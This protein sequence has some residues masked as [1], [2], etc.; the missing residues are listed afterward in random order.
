MASILGAIIGRQRGA[1]RVEPR[2]VIPGRQR[3]DIDV[4]LGRPNVA[5]LL[6]VELRRLLGVVTIYVN[7]VT[8]RVLIHHD[9]GLSSAE[10]DQFVREAVVLVVRQAMVLTTPS[11]HEPDVMPPQLRHRRPTSSSFTIAGSAVVGVAALVVHYRRSPFVRLGALLAATVGVVR[12]AWRKASQARPTEPSPVGTRRHHILQIVGSHRRQFYLASALSIIGQIL[13]MTPALI[14]GWT[15]VV[16]INGQSA[17]FAFQFATVSSQLLFLTGM[18]ALICIIFIVVATLSFS[19]GT[20][21]RNLA[22]SVQHDWRTKMYAH[23]QKVGLPYLES[24]RTT[25]ITTVLTHDIN[26]L[27]RFFITTWP[28]DFLQLCTSFI[29]LVSMFICFAPDIAW[30]VLA[31]VPIIVWLSFFYREHMAPHYAKNGN[32]WSLLNSQLINNLE[33]SATVKSFCAEDY[34]IDRIHRLS[35]AYRQSNHWI[36]TRAVA[37]GT[38]VRLCSATSVVGI[39][40][41]GGRA[42]LCGALPFEVFNFLAAGLPQRVLFQLPRLGDAVDQYQQ[43]VGA[44]GRVQALL[45]LPA[46]PDDSG[47]QLDVA[48]VRGELV[49]DGVTFGYP[50]HPPL[51]NN[52]SL[53]IAAKKTIGIVGGTGAGKTTIAKLMLR[54][55]DVTSGRVLLDGLD[56]RELNLRD[57]RN[58]IGFVAQDAFLID[59]TVR[60]NIRYGRFDADAERVVSAARL[61]KADAFV[62]DLPFRYDTMIGE[63]GATLSGGQKQ[64]VSLARTILKSAPVIIL[65]EA[66]SAVDNE[67]EAAIQRT[68][69]EFARDRTM[70]IIAHRLSTIRHADQI[71]VLGK[72]GVVAETGTHQELLQRNGIYASLWNLQNGETTE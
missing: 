29:V 30:I 43:T 31:P 16:L 19:A 68:L 54:F 24:E 20:L 26:Q 8:G 53:R 44:L 63:R 59:G 40:L 51:F 46:E 25:R 6:E 49:F 41:L 67:T 33:A 47:R 50:G 57:L 69:R 22:Q 12:R 14:I 62:E 2:S 45:R 58:A 65:D 4:V 1:L 10:V 32:N 11:A 48:K 17:A 23:V 61:A 7:P 66:T 56:I 38:I 64:R 55:H 5:E 15:I 39:L 28:N 21:W 34:E 52:L 35:E 37:Y 3:W 70:V 13:E 27:G 18:V 72:G 9:M 60:D 42:A 71:F 36:D